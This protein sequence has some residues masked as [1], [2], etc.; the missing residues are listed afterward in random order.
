MTFSARERSLLTI[1]VSRQLRLRRTPCGH[2]LG[3]T[4]YYCIRKIDEA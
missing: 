2:F 4:M 3:I 1:N